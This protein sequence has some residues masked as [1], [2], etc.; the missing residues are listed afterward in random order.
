MTSE[1][2]RSFARPAA[3]LTLRF[4]DLAMVTRFE[5][6]ALLGMELHEDRIADGSPERRVAARQED[7]LS[8]LYLEVH[9]FAQEHLLIDRRLPHV[10]SGGPRLG[11]LDVLGPHRKDNPV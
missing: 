7:P 6:H 3:L 5:G 4:L 2:Q 1:P 9:E 10:V 8:D 11:E